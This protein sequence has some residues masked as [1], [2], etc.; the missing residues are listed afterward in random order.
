MQWSTYEEVL[1]L[2]NEYKL[3]EAKANKIILKVNMIYI[4]SRLNRM[5]ELLKGF[6]TFAS[7]ISRAMTSITNDLK[8]I[9][10]IN[11]E[12]TKIGRIDKG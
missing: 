11:D 2:H 12:I 10:V 8:R 3:I 1:K 7:Q 6:S 4:T 9:L 5:R